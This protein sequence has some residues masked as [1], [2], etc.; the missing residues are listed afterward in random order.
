MGWIDITSQLTP[1]EGAV[2]ACPAQDAARPLYVWNGAYFEADPHA[3]P[4][5]DP[6][7]GG[8]YPGAADTTPAGYANRGTYPSLLYIG[9]LIPDV[10]KYRITFSL[11]VAASS[12]D[13]DGAAGWV[14]FGGTEGNGCFGCGELPSVSTTS[15]QVI[16]VDF[17][18]LGDIGE[19]NPQGAYSAYIEFSFFDP[20]NSRA[21]Y[22][23]AN[24]HKVEVF[25]E[26]ASVEFWTDFVQSEERSDG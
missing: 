12:I 16:E 20:P 13:L 5:G 22:V 25:S 4:A 3:Y 9:A 10:T 21:Y 15:T 14:T 24:I 19:G 7:W 11:P 26:T 2:V 6:T 8:C 17:A 18:P 23:M 1:T